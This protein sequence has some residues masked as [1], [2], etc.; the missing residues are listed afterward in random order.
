MRWLGVPCMLLLGCLFDLPASPDGPEVSPARTRRIDITDAQVVGGPHADFPLLVSIAQPWLRGK[1]AGGC[2]AHASGFDIGFFAD[3]AGTMRLA[4][5]VEVYRSDANM[6]TLVAWVKVPSLSATSELFLRYGD[7]E[8]TM[9]KENAAAVWSNGFS[10]VWHLSAL[11]DS[12]ANANAGT[13]SGST[14][15]PARIGDE[16]E[17]RIGVALQL[18]RPSPGNVRVQLEALAEAEALRPLAV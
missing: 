11:G 6:G 4:H 9:S 12:T 16:Q 8:I 1:A 10:A 15:A 2:I 5:E 3:A 13:N 17:Q 14:A 7:P 18:E